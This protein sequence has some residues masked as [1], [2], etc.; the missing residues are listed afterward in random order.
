[1]DTT[2]IEGDKKGIIQLFFL[3]VDMKNKFLTELKE[4]LSNYEI[5]VLINDK[6]A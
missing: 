1:M 3:K 6:A 2:T 5:D 4:I